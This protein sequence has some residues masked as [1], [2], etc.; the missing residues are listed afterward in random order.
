MKTDVF[1]AKTLVRTH[2]SGA[3]K[4]SAQSSAVL[5]QQLS[6]VEVQKHYYQNHKDHSSLKHIRVQLIIL[7]LIVCIG[8]TQAL[9]FVMHDLID[10]PIQLFVVTV[11]AS[12][13]RSITLTKFDLQ[14]S[15]DSYLAR[16]ILNL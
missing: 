9:R 8:I 6:K 3:G 4:V 10:L 5:V 15:G 13:K 16:N 14:N 1:G 11:V 2:F 7:D 12:N